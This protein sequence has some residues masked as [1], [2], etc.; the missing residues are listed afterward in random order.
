MNLWALQEKGPIDDILTI[1][2][3]A[4]V[5]MPAAISAVIG[6]CSQKDNAAAL[7]TLGPWLDTLSFQ[8]LDTIL[9]EKIK[10]NRAITGFYKSAVDSHAKYTLGKQIAQ[11]VAQ[12]SESF[13]PLFKMIEHIEARLQPH[14]WEASWEVYPTLV[15]HGLGLY[16]NWTVP[17]MTLCS[18]PMII[19]QYR[20]H[21]RKIAYARAGATL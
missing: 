8:K 19:S 6:Y 10:N 14:G 11:S 15:M 7:S 3:K 12:K 5:P 17:W 16:P 13:Y 2:A 21:E 18:L 9:D 1:Y 4:E 20:C